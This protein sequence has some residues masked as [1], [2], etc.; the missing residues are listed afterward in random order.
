V[1]SPI[2]TF[3]PRLLLAEN[4][5]QIALAA[6]VRLRWWAVIGQIGATIASIIFLKL[7]LPL[8]PIAAV[9]AFTAFSN[10]ILLYG[11]RRAKTPPSLV[12]AVLLT[13]VGSL[14]ALLYLTGGSAN[15]FCMLYLVH[16]AMAVIVLGPPWMWIVVAACAASYAMLFVVR[17]PFAMAIPPW[18]LNA[19]SWFAL[20]LVAVLISVFIGRIERALRIRERELSEVREQVAQ[21]ERLASLTTL[22]AGAAHELNTPLGTIALV[23]KELEVGTNTS[24]VREDAKLIR[25]E[26][27]R[28]RQI[29]NRMRLEIGEDVSLRRRVPVAEI[30]DHIR[31]QLRP[32]E[33]GRLRVSSGADVTDVL[34]PARA[35]E[36]ALLVLVRNAFDASPPDAT[37]SLGI[38]RRDGVVSFSVEDKGAGMSDDLLRRAGEPFFTTKEPGKGMGLGLFLVRLVAERCGAKLRIESKEKMGTRCV[39]ELPDGR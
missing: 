21:N 25:A 27:E 23:A 2:P 38:H 13:D 16:V 36:Q 39:F 20:L 4:E 34:A 31:Q 35:L 11:S 15:P 30:V 9:V 32:E 3:L 37:V 14:T 10:V 6:L 24:E 7:E 33:A 26:V 22:A 1:K 18:V 5:P 28:C 17:V 19:G 12:Q 29:L 8:I